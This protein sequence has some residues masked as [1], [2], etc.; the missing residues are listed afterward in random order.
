[1][2]QR[3][4]VCSDTHFGHA[5]IIRYCDR[6]FKSVEHMDEELIARWNARVTSEDIVYFLGDF[7]FSP[8]WRIRQIF[9]QLNFEKCIIVPG[10][11]DRTL[12]EMWHQPFDTFVPRVELVDQL[13]DIRV[14]GKHFVLCHYPMAEWN[15]SHRGSIHL[16]G[17]CH[18]SKGKHKTQ[19]MPGRYDIGVDMFGGPVRVT[20]DLRFLDDP[21][22]WA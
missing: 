5:N 14:E 22:G 12:L 17:H 7:A 6:P 18:G 8:V 15:G 2:T 11:H 10:N 13:H 3:T 9:E 1:M 16:H 21:K 20:G 4:F 19:P